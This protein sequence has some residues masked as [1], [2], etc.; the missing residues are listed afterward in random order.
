MVVRTN[1][2]ERERERV[3]RTTRGWTVRLDDGFTAHESVTNKPRHFFIA[4]NR[5]EIDRL[6]L[7]YHCCYTTSLLLDVGG[8][9]LIKKAKVRTS[10]LTEVSRFWRKSWESET[11]G[12][13]W[14]QFQRSLQPKE[15]EFHHHQNQHLLF[16]PSLQSRHCKE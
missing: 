3:N 13:V 6:L 12:T 15:E 4:H 5:I 2:R 14:Y 9:K 1:G 7:D 10:W 11:S 16:V 8:R